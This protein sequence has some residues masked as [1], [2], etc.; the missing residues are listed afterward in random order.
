MRFNRQFVESFASCPRK[1]IES[2][3]RPVELAQ[4]T[5]TGMVTNAHF[6]FTLNCAMGTQF[7]PTQT[8]YNVCPSINQRSDIGSARH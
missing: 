5:Q 8:H 6:D 1:C 3:A 2:G 7:L 4:M